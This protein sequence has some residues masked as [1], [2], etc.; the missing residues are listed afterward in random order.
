M[1]KHTHTLP[2]QRGDHPF[3]LLSRGRHAEAVECVLEL[4]G[5]DP[6]VVVRVELVERLLQRLLV[7][8]RDETRFNGGSEETLSLQ[9]SKHLAYHID[10]WSFR[11]AT[12]I[13]LPPLRNREPAHRVQ[14]WLEMVSMGLLL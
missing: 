2:V 13:A 8:L 14:R 4:L 10:R 7:R 12:A 11:C 3:A 5:A 9:V 1:E 6:S